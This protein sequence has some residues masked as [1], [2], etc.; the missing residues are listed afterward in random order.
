MNQGP[1][2][3]NQNQTH[4]KFIGPDGITY[5]FDDSS[6]IYKPDA[7]SATKQ[8]H[9]DEHN[10]QPSSLYR[11]EV[12]RDWWVFGITTLIA[13]AT[14]V[15]VSI[16]T[17]YAQ[18]QT[19]ISESANYNFMKSNRDAARSVT[20][21]LREMEAQV[22]ETRKQA[23][24]SDRASNAAVSTYEN[25]V[26]PYIGVVSLASINHDNPRPALN[27]NA[28]FT[29]H[30]SIPAE[31]FECS[32]RVFLGGVEQHIDK[33]PDKPKSL[34]PS[35][36]IVIAGQIGFDDAPSVINGDKSLIFYAS[37]SYKWRDKT[38]KGCQA[39]QYYPRIKGGAFTSLGPL[40]PEK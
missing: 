31:D 18:K 4:G 10:T 8:N 39:F 15:I 26:R 2:K 11:V 27:F 20:L 12:R 33:I 35:T 16:Y 9:N 7:A 30:G 13:V 22:E 23:G 3:G 24:S 21:T 29:N 6:R 34:P 28:V 19:Y 25:T 36:P 5:I 1:N 32:W 38:E 37:Y 14:F 17:Y 40:C